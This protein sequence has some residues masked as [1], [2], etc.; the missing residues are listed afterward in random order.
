MGR[1]GGATFPPARPGRVTRPR[2]PRRRWWRRRAREP[3]RT[4]TR[5]DLEAAAGELEDGWAAV[6]ALLVYACRRVLEELEPTETGHVSQ[7]L[8]RVDPVSSSSRVRA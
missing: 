8:A 6:V 7:T 1:R 4:V 3:S 2:H 5:E